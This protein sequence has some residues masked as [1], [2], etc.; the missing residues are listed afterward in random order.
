MILLMNLLP[1][2]K[3]KE[4]I[5]NLCAEKHISPN[6]P[7]IPNCTSRRNNMEADMIPVRKDP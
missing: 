3:R 4:S 5:L 7:P 2:H 6:E 1:S